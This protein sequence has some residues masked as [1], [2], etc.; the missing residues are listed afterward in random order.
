MKN[1][2]TPELTILLT[3]KVK[4]W[5]SKRENKEVCWRDAVGGENGSAW[6]V[7][8]WRAGVRRRGVRLGWGRAKAGSWTISVQALITSN[9]K[10]YIS[11]AKICKPSSSRLRSA[12]HPSLKFTKTRGETRRIYC[13]G[14]Q[15]AVTKGGFA[16]HKGRLTF[17]AAVSGTISLSTP[18]K[19]SSILEIY[20]CN[21]RFTQQ[22]FRPF[23]MNSGRFFVSFDF[24]KQILKCIVCW[25]LAGTFVR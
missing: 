9:P 10:W 13:D 6:K 25:I 23:S 20:L 24:R 12:F 22:A 8:G 17:A 4:I 5:I 15:W 1:A 19:M 2:L 14:K 11:V 16:G 18:R 7:G 21:V 3:W